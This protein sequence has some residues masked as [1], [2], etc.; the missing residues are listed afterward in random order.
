VDLTDE[1]RRTADDLKAVAAQLDGMR[2]GMEELAA[3]IESGKVTSVQDARWAF[4][5][6]VLSAGAGEV[7]VEVKPSS[8]K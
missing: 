8:G 2:K 6:S 5:G 1:K 3:N 4:L 7:K